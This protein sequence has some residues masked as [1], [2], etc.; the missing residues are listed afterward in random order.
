[1]GRYSISGALI[2]GATAFLFS[3]TPAISSDQLRA[4]V[5]K[6]VVKM[7]VSP[8]DAAKLTPA[9]LAQAELILNDSEGATKADQI[10]ALLAR[11]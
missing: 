6:Q 8:Q 10:R 3:V 5:Q 11:Q 7:G 4:N 2:A 9:A 1:M